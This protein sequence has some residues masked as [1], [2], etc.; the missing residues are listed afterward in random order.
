MFSTC[1]RLLGFWGVCPQGHR[2]STPGPQTPLLS[3]LLGKFL[4]TPLY[5]LFKHTQVN[6]KKL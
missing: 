4:A 6:L 3:F 2:G 5:I 1:L